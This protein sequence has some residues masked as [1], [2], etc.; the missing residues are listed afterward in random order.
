MIYDFAI[1]DFIDKMAV[2]WG[3]EFKVDS[4][5]SSVTQYPV[6]FFADGR[7][8]MVHTGILEVKYILEDVFHSSSSHRMDL[9]YGQG[10][11]V[12]Q[13]FTRVHNFF[14]K[15]TQTVV[16][17]TEFQLILFSWYFSIPPWPSQ[18]SSSY[19]HGATFESL[20]VMFMEIV[21]AKG[22]FTKLSSSLAVILVSFSPLHH[23][24]TGRSNA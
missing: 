13:D 22:W 1:L 24:K 20:W 16:L 17:Y 9:A 15:T 2:L 12:N 10:Q 19:I 11:C 18:V 6:I 3:R 23:G 5:R 7:L 14:K 8:V 21:E 4:I